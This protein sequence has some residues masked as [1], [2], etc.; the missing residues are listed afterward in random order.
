MR[1]EAC[2]DEGPVDRNDKEDGDGM[3]DV[4]TAMD[5]GY[6]RSRP[7]GAGRD[8]RRRGPRPR[9]PTRR[10]HTLLA[11]L[12]AAGRQSLHAAAAAG[13][14]PDA[15]TEHLSDAGAAAGAAAAAADR[16]ARPE[17]QA[18]PPAEPGAAGPARHD[19]TAGQR[20]DPPDR[21]PGHVSELLP[22]LPGAP[23][24]ARRAGAAPLQAGRSGLLRTPSLTW[25]RP[26][27]PSCVPRRFPSGCSRAWA[28]TC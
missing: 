21:A 1:W 17:P 10:H 18:G 27:P 23:G 26:G 19:L 24:A 4:A 2:G 8:R 12:P 9:S 6:G 15:V 7:A 20:V 11:D 22:L 16:H 13:L 5:V 14:Q 25:R 28:C 3:H